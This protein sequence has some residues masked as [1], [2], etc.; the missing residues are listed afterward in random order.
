M[1]SENRRVMEQGQEVAVLPRITVFWSEGRRYAVRPIGWWVWT[2]W[3]LQYLVTIVFLLAIYGNV[4]QTRFECVAFSC[5]A[6][7]YLDM[8][9]ERS[10]WVVEMLQERDHRNEI[11][12]HLSEKLGKPLMPEMTGLIKEL[13]GQTEKMCT[14]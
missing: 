1:T 9:S 3:T 7:I 10:A 6:L 11:Y 4:I 13:S 14:Y 2:K 12:V 5:L 8:V